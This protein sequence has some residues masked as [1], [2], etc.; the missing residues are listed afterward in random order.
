M[1]TNSQLMPSKRKKP[2]E[3]ARPTTPSRRKG[4]SAPGEPR[5]IGLVYIL[6]ALLLYGFF[7]LYPFGQSIWIS[8]FD[9]DG[10]TVATWT[11]FSNYADVFTDPD[12]RNAFGHSIFLLIFYAVVPV[13]IGLIIAGIVSRA[14][15]RGM[16]VYRTIIFMPQVLAMVVVGVA[17]RYMLAPE[18]FI[19][20]TLNAI[21]LDGVSR[22]WLGDYTFALPAVGVI[23]SWV[24]TGLCMVLFIAG[25][26]Q[27]PKELF[28]AAR[29]DGA[30]PVREFFAVTLPALR[31]HVAVASTLTIIS[32]MRNFDLIY[33]TTSQGPGKAT[34]VPSYE[35]YSRAFETNQVGS[36]TAIGVTLTAVILII[37]T[38]V[39]KTIEGRTR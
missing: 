28:E 1:A 36:A 38:V 19:N 6:P 37:T 26:Q 17:W 21:G 31:P 7:L 39:A 34:S 11:G 15:L 16:S 9:W 33:I 29:I 13:A 18:G 24:Q 27:I 3:K 12:I 5:T 2:A 35:I 32:G 23:G 8:L 20:Q 30:G 10:L 22:A 25:A 4:D 14:T